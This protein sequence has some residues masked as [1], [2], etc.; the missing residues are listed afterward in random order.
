ML[1]R[2]ATELRHDEQSYYGRFD[3]PDSSILK[4]AG[5]PLCQVMIGP[6]I[7]GRSRKRIPARSD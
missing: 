1:R 2:M 7:S 3:S 4:Q 6:K 5:E